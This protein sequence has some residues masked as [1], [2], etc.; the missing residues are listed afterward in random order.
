[1]TDV[2]DV[3]A[4]LERGGAAVLVVPPAPE[5]A[6][7]VWRLVPEP[8]DGAPPRAVIACGDAAGAADWVAAAPAD[9]RVHPLTGLGRAA[10]LLKDRRI[11]VL[12]GAVP[13]LAALVARSVLKLE[14]VP[15]VVLAWPEAALGGE[16]AAALDLLLGEARNARRIIL[17][18]NPALLGDFLERHAHRAPVFGDLPLGPDARPLPPIGPARFVIVPPDRR[19]SAVRETLDALN[20][21]RAFVWTPDSAHAARL[22][23]LLGASEADVSIDTEPREG[24][25]DAV[26]CA[27]LPSRAQL[28][29]LSRMAEP[30]LLVSAEQLPYLRSIA[31]PLRTLP[32]PSGADR[33]RD[34]AGTF[35]ARVAERLAAG[36][37]DA[38]LALLDPLFERFDPAE[39]AAAIYAISRQPPAPGEAPDSTTAAPWVKVFVNLGKKD[40]VGAKDLVGALIRE[41]KLGKGD[42]GRIEVRDAFCVVEIAPPVADAAIRGL[43]GITI[44]GRRV[45]ARRDR[46][47]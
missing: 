5:Q 1:M 33:A 11:D 28:A 18:W 9:R 40:Q 12:A 30:V 16:H 34:R 7:P 20:P 24:A 43:A 27:R 19:L 36:D 14:A 17:S 26:I 45:A 31:G 41:V 39:V 23:G 29:A 32:L 15:L 8:T 47:A 10:R 22:R 46:E 4:A 6:R 42:I 35:R 21:P 37:V 3:Q 44:R 13:D 25:F 38:E 2:R